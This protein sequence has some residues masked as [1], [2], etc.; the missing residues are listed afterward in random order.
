MLT[1]FKC[2]FT[3]Y[4]RAA[5]PFVHAF[6]LKTLWHWYMVPGFGMKDI[7]I[8]AAI[9]LMFV[10]GFLTHGLATRSEM[11][12]KFAGDDE[13]EKNKAFGTSVFFTFFYPPLV[14]LMGYLFKGFV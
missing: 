1:F 7:S 13:E 9:G 10:A 2:L 11:N 12:Q 6:L 3:G 14:L 4:C 8:G 5:E